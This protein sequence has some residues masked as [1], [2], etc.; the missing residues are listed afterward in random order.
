MWYYCIASHLYPLRK[1]G[2]A[3]GGRAREKGLSR[4]IRKFW[5]WI[6]LL[7]S[8]T[9]G[10]VQSLSGITRSKCSTYVSNA[11]KR[12]WH[13]VEV[14]I[15]CWARYVYAAKIWHSTHCTAPFPFRFL[16]IQVSILHGKKGRGGTTDTEL[17]VTMTHITMTHRY[18]IERGGTTD[19]NLH[20]DGNVG[21][22][23]HSTVQCQHL[24]KAIL[25]RV[26]SGLQ[27]TWSHR[28]LHTSA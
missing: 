15:V 4:Q 1:K 5:I 24:G 19:T 27:C 23:Q 3:R 14:W 20:D 17:K 22:L 26:I 28:E 11:I 2:R 7:R 10:A 25:Y 18:W 6:L 21:C 8:L 12:G 9:N 13:T 16:K